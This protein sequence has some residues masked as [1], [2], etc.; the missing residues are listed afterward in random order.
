MPFRPSG[1]CALGAF[2]TFQSK[3]PSRSVF[4]RLPSSPTFCG[5]NPETTL[6]L[7]VLC[8]GASDQRGT[9]DFIQSFGF[10]LPSLMGLVCLP[11]VGRIPSALTFGT[12]HS[13]NAASSY[14]RIRPARKGLFQ[15]SALLPWTFA[16]SSIKSVPPTDGFHPSSVCGTIEGASVWTSGRLRCSGKMAIRCLPDFVK[17]EYQAFYLFHF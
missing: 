10:R 6:G 13:R 8:A 4:A 17:F 7:G 15:T 16:I 2:S 14:C 3:H 12:F 5:G 1:R 9:V 11:L